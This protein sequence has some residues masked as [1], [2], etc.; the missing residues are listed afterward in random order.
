MM[1][2]HWRQRVT[3][4]HQLSVFI[5]LLIPLVL[6]MFIV[7]GAL[8]LFIMPISSEAGSTPASSP[9]ST[10]EELLIP[11]QTSS[12]IVWAIVS[13]GVGIGTAVFM[14]SRLSRPV[15]R[16]ADAAK[17]IGARQ[18][19][20]RVP[21]SGSR[22]MRQLATAFNQMASDL[23]QAETHRRQLMADVSHELRTPLAALE[24]NLRA[25]LDDVYQLTEAEVAHL[26]GQTRTLIHLVDD[27]HEL[28]LAEADQ[29]PLTLQKTDILQLLQETVAIFEPLAVEQGIDLQTEWPAE[30]PCLTVDGLRIRQILHNLIGNGLRHTP[31]NGRVHVQAIPANDAI[32]I[33]VTDSGDGIAPEHLPFVFDRFYRIDQSRS[34]DT[35]GAGLGLAIAKAIMEAHN[36]RIWVS[37]QGSGKGT[38]FTV[39]LLNV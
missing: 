35:G 34:R 3:P 18:L 25:A 12:L 22:E 31:V 1:M 39:E 6:M 28:A 23:Q 38:R 8:I 36:G 37:S 29:L 24:G 9:N 7:M 32:Q 14:S 19:A 20:H 26:Y 5:A 4:S 21:V 16:V 33:S 2:R 13:G 27:L 10:T 15:T 30:L 17:A 11:V